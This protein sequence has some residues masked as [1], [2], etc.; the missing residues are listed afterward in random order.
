MKVIPYQDIYCG[1]VWENSSDF[2]FQQIDYK[3]CELYQIQD[4]LYNFRIDL[5]KIDPKYL[6][7]YPL[8]MLY[9]F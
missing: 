5:S 4:G 9:A 8:S 6:S 7:S 1:L 2:F 3:T